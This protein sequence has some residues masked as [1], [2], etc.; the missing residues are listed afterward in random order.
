MTLTKRDLVVRI[1][2]ETGLN[3]NQVFAVVQKILDHITEALAKGGNA[4]IRNFGI[5]EVKIRKARVG[6]NPH[7]PEIDVPIPARAIVKFKAGK[8]MGEM[9]LKLKPKPA[10]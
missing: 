2:E 4:E 3:Q 9:V 8:E 10:K 1:S 6:R 5:F 7:R